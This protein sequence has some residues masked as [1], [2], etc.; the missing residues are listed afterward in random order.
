MAFNRYSQR[1]IHNQFNPMSM[2]ELMVLPQFKQQQHEMAVATAEALKTQGQVLSKDE[3]GFNQGAS[4]INKGI[5]NIVDQLSKDGIQSDT[6]NNILSLKRKKEDFL[7]P[8]SGFGGKALSN[9]ALYQKA[10]EDMDQMR[11]SG[12]Y[13]N[14]D[15]ENSL[16]RAMK[17][18]EGVE[19]GD[20]FAY[21]APAR[22]VDMQKK[23][24]DVL[25]KVPINEIETTLG[26]EEMGID[27]HTGEK[28][29]RHGSKIIK[30]RSAEHQAMV[31]KA[32]LQNDPEVMEYLRDQADFAE[33]LYSTKEEES[34][35]IIYSDK[36]YNPDTFQQQFI[37]EKINNIA[38]MGAEATDVYSV[39]NKIDYKFSKLEE[40]YLNALNAAR[41]Q[42]AIVGVET[43]YS[44]NTNLGTK[45]YLE[46]I[47]KG[48]G[49]QFKI[50]VNDKKVKSTD[51]SPDNWP[52]GL[53]RK[54]FRQQQEAWGIERSKDGFDY[55]RYWMAD[56]M[57]GFGSQA[58]DVDNQYN[59]VKGGSIETPNDF[60]QLFKERT[61]GTRYEDWPEEVIDALYNHIT[62]EANVD[63]KYTKNFGYGKKRAL[64]VTPTGKGGLLELG[65]S[66]ADYYAEMGGIHKILG[67][68]IEKLTEEEF[69]AKIVKN[70]EM[71]FNAYQAYKLS[72]PNATPEDF[73]EYHK[74][75]LEGA[76]NIKTEIEYIH[77]TEPTN[78]II[79][80]IMEGKTL[81]THLSNQDVLVRQI[82][83]SKIKELNSKA[84]GAFKSLNDIEK[85]GIVDISRPGV[86]RQHGD[87]Y[88]IGGYQFNV[89]TKEGN[90]YSITTGPLDK[91]D[92]IVYAPFQQ[93]NSSWNNRTNVLRPSQVSENSSVHNEVEMVAEK[94]DGFWLNSQGEPMEELTYL[95]ESGIVPEDKINR[96]TKIFSAYSAFNTYGSDNTIQNRGI[97]KMY[98]QDENGAMIPLVDPSI[99]DDS[100]IHANMEDL[101]IEEQ[102]KLSVARMLMYDK[103]SFRN[104]I[105]DKKEVQWFKSTYHTAPNQVK[106]IN[107]L[108]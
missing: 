61:K 77:G 48:A 103:D 4:E 65:S 30:E 68:D 58:Y 82:T 52:P 94:K 3:E 44:T 89:T 108:D 100:I 29:Y 5:T 59:V 45:E 40:G 18:Y 50:V 19:T 26:L 47:K 87:S 96:N 93:M 81:T 36:Y 35:S 106:F 85:E 80:G 67:I 60:R 83:D 34:G 16:A 39:K 73:N 17:N 46:T 56:K 11:K 51:Y 88:K 41:E 27:Q 79:N 78:N 49:N 101:S 42:S 24:L 71:V 105:Q 33:Q 102:R 75:Q 37:N 1:R 91:K 76:A 28:I 99:Y 54:E 38:A 74:T 22:Y 25:D 86:V 53:S 107:S 12:K 95:I 62:N 9:F 15:I 14:K 23:V 10:R 21:Q 72:N 13:L 98:I 32:Y 84:G 20:V 92:A 55:E 64:I 2:Q 57:G 69:N 8:N 6:F 66:T 90:T 97:R 43:D 7:D 31:A 63:G 104:L 70:N